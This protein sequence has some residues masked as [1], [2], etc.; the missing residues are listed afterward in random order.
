MRALGHETCKVVSGR[1]AATVYV[2]ARTYSG[3]CHAQLQSNLFA[4]MVIMMASQLEMLRRGVDRLSVSGQR[5]IIG[6]LGSRDRNAVTVF[7]SSAGA[8]EQ[9]TGNGGR[10]KLAQDS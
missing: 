7:D 8:Q 9:C 5:R 10:Q 4:V 2:L 1:N 6:V 3:V